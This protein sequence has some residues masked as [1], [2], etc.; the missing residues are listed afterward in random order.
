[1]RLDLSPTSK[2][3]RAY[4]CT[5]P[6]CSQHPVNSVKGTITTTSTALLS[7]TLAARYFFTDVVGSFPFD[8]MLSAFHFPS[9]VI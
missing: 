8:R 4:D 1:M 6:W 9:D 5:T 7:I 2:S 3:N